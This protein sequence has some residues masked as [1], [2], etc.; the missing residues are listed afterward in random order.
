MGKTGIGFEPQGMQLLVQVPNEYYESKS[1]II[2]S[3]VDKAAQRRLY[4]E[5]GDK[6]VVAAVGSD[7]RF[8]KL[9]DM[10]AVALRG[11]LELELDGIEEP[12]VLIRE[13]EVLG[14]YDK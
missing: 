14:R 3:D 1:D 7:C 8:A 13:S 5:R 4:I 2:I 10:V 11:S 12:F 6:M 9:G